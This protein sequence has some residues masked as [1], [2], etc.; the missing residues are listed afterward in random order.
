MGYQ[1]TT[2]YQE[3]IGATEP[4]SFGLWAQRIRSRLF[5]Y[6]PLISVV[7]P[8]HNVAIE[9]LQKAV[10]SVLAQTYHR[11]QLC[12]VDDASSDPHLKELLFS[13]Q[14]DKRIVVSLSDSPRG[15]ATTTNAAVDMS[16]GELIAFMDHDD[17]LAPQALYQVVALLNRDCGADLIYSD[18]D[19]FE[20]GTS[21][22]VEPFFKPSWSQELLTQMNYL[23]HLTVTSREL[24]DRVG[25]LRTGF[26]GSQ[27]HDLVLRASEK[28]N[29]VAH[30]P[31]ILYHWRKVPGSAA[32][33]SD[34]KSYAHEAGR[35]AVADHLERVGIDADVEVITPGRYRL[36]HRTD[37]PAFELIVLPEL[38]VAD[39]N[40]AAARSDKDLLLFTSDASSVGENGSLREMACYAMRPGLALV[41]GLVVDSGGIIVEAGLVIESDGS[42]RRAMS[43]Q[44]HERPFYF[45]LARAARECTSSSLVLLM[46]RRDLFL[47]L[48]GLD[49]GLVSPYAEADLGLRAL[50]RG[51]RNICFP[52]SLAKAPLQELGG[53][54]TSLPI[55]RD[56]WDK[57]IR[58]GDPYFPKALEPNFQEFRMRVPNRHERISSAGR[59]GG[60]T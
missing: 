22:R 14:T 12:I 23:S 47:E 19:K 53:D 35:K 42:V 54:S 36:K 24:F 37:P 17:E 27:D 43:G 32:M 29:K 39:A 25:G 41:G 13:L 18:E 59:K 28:A 50:A 55:F 5:A 33:A 57:V 4:G 15:I 8:V 31:S 9:F 60:R 51:L 38:S 6:K 48:G 11:W 2:S 58:E 21:N 3:W 46:V 16:A 49:E 45:H 1:L 44:P 34:A 20:E 30:I 40:Q 10:D 7:M 56:L 52:E 26:E